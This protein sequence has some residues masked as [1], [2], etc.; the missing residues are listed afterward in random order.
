MC[1]VA[2][3]TLALALAFLAGVVCSVAL[4]SLAQPRLEVGLG[5]TKFHARE[6]GTWWQSQYETH[7]D[8]TSASWRLA[9]RDYFTG[10]RHFGWSLGYSYLGSFSG[11]NRASLWDEEVG[12]IPADGSA[13]DFENK[14]HGC[15]GWFNG[16][17]KARG[18]TLGLTADRTIRGLTFGVEGGV[19]V[20]RSSYDVTLHLDQGI[21]FDDS[22]GK[23]PPGSTYE[24]NHATGTHGTWYVGYRAS[25][26][27]LFAQ[28]LSFHNVFEQGRGP[29]GDVGLTGGRTK[30]VLVGISVPI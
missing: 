27:Y 6:D 2:V 4:Q 18:V 21:N 17:G 24:Y 13:C 7:N 29:G 3:R 22:R 16:S 23:F 10:S 25:Y 5:Q 30:Q 14:S 20:F 26:G 15:L 9:L 12:R 11:H 28:V 1:G 19:F 8:L